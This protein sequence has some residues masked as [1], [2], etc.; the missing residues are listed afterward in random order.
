MKNFNKAVF[1]V[2]F[3]TILVGVVPAQAAEA[4]TKYTLSL[5]GKTNVAS[6]PRGT[7]PKGTNLNPTLKID[8]N[9]V[10]TL[11][12]YE[13]S[14]VNLG[15]KTAKGLTAIQVSKLRDISVSDNGK[16][17]L[18]IQYNNAIDKDVNSVKETVTIQLSDQRISSKNVGKKYG[19]KVKF[20]IVV[21]RLPKTVGEIEFEENL[22]KALKEINASQ[23][24]TEF[25]KVTA[26]YEW[27]TNNI[28]Y[29]WD[30][31]DRKSNKIASAS[32]ALRE[33]K[34]VC[35]GYA[36]L[37]DLLCGEVGIE[38][39]R[40]T[41]TANGLGSW[42]LHAWNIVKIDGLWYFVD[43]TWDIAQDYEYFLKTSDYFSEDHTLDAGSRDKIKKSKIK[44]TK[45]NY[46]LPEGFLE[47]RS[48]ELN[49]YRLKPVGSFCC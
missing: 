41:G 25:E 38:S 31:Y 23:Y 30:G 5:T 26:V 21:K 28:E 43:S 17:Y 46:E 44:L 47:E 37:F 11:T 35:D 18:T 6:L 13:G 12:M 29:D 27:I 9:G 42:E 2:M 19:T 33:H 3:L 20:K 34:A 48:E 32:G 1:I 14:K 39:M 4:T 10:Y 15:V 8:K 24:K 16:G 40:V 22:D 45:D 7:Y 36:R 49:H